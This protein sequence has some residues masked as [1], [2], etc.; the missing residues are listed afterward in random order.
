MND[1]LTSSKY[2]LTLLEIKQLIQFI[3]DLTAK[4]KATYEVV[5]TKFANICIFR[6]FISNIEKISYEWTDLVSI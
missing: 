6:L 1:H 4:E 3:F 5:N 2:I